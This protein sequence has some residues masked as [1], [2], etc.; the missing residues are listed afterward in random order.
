VP[1]S[2]VI[3]AAVSDI[4]STIA[5]TNLLGLKMSTAGIAALLMLIGYSVDTDILL[6]TK[7]LKTT[8]AIAMN[9]KINAFTI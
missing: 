9:A 5:V 7:V 4:I 8:T 2:C 3:L 1:S 6:T